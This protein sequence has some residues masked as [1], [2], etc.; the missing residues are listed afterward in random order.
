MRSAASCT[1][2]AVVVRKAYGM[3][4]PARWRASFINPLSRKVSACCTFIPGAP[5]VSR[6]LA[7]STTVGSHSVSTRSTLI[8]RSAP[9]TVRMAASS[10]AHEPTWTYFQSASRAASG[11]ASTCWSP[12]PITL[13][14]T[15]ANPRVNSGISPGYP[16]PRKRTSVIAHRAEGSAS[17]EAHAA[18][19]GSAAIDEPAI[20]HGIR[21]PLGTLQL[22]GRDQLVQRALD[23]GGVGGPH[24]DIAVALVGARR[25][26]AGRR[27]AQIDDQ[28]TR[29]RA[30]AVE[31]VGGD[32]RPSVALRPHVGGAD[33]V[34]PL[35]RVELVV[36]GQ[37]GPGGVHVDVVGVGHECHELG[38]R[39]AG[40][41]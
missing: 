36:D 6:S 14:P 9:S 35:R 22:D 40:A 34:A 2:A 1:P 29:G 11:T 38:A 7:A 10:S 12:T 25:R 8:P 19:G 26:L 18:R 21:R 32:D 28:V 33:G 5:M 23:L 37:A 30:D 15:S 27:Q 24:D 4:M 20:Q 16:G 31:P 13:A 41:D 39:W 3:R 17:D